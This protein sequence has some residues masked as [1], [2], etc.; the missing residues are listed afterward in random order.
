MKQPSKK[1]VVVVSAWLVGWLVGFF[2]NQ[3]SKWKIIL[4]QESGVLSY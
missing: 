2:L 4:V 3:S 1:S